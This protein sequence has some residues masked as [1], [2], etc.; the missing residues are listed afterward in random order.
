LFIESASQ[1][2]V[3][4]DVKPRKANELNRNV[5]CCALMPFQIIIGIKCVEIA[6]YDALRTAAPK[7]SAQKANERIACRGVISISSPACWALVLS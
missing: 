4:V 3:T 5:A 7:T 6:W 1:P 2:S